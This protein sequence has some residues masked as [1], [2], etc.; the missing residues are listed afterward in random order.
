MYMAPMTHQDSQRIRHSREFWLLMGIVS[1]ALVL[2]LGFAVLTK[3]WLFPGEWQFG[4]EMGEIASSLAEGHGFSR[5]SKSPHLFEPTAWMA[6]VYPWLMAAVFKV[7][8]TYSSHAA[9]ILELFQTVL[10]TLACILVHFLG[11][12]LFNKQVGLLSALLLAIYPPSISLAVQRIWSASLFVCCLLLILL[13]FIRLSEHPSIKGGFFLGLILGFTALLDPIIVSLYPFAFVWLYLKAEGDRPTVLRMVIP[14]FL[15][16]CLSIA[17]WIVRNYVVFGQF[18]FI[19][20]NLG[21]ELFLGKNAFA[22]GIADR[23]LKK[24]VSGEIPS[25]LLSEAERAYLNQADE[26]SRN[27]LYRRKGINFIVEHPSRFVQLSLTRFALFWT[28]MPRTRTLQGKI[29]LGIYLSMLTLA[30]IGLCLRGTKGREVQLV[31]LCLLSLPLPY[32]FTVVAHGRYRFP[33]EPLLMIFAGYT[34]Y[35]ITCY[36]RQMVVRPKNS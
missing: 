28:H 26:A 4:F 18:M 25:P 11:K 17:P 23:T 7:F 20:S 2:R 21:H 5:P 22:E 16:S 14:I 3:S 9:M 12:R 31:F 32:Y 36:A 6:P 29:T 10:S 27:R 30:V 35:R 33:V 13:F 1:V 34:I 24:Q 8:G 15:M 19:K